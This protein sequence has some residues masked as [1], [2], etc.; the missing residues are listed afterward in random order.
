MVVVDCVE[1]CGVQTEIVLRQA[2]Q[3][4]VMPNL[5]VNDVECCSLE[6]QMEPED[7]YGPFR[8]ANEN[9]HVIT[10]TY[11]DALLGDVQVAPETGIVAFRQ[12]SAE[13][14]VKINV[15][16]MGVDKEKMTK[17]LWE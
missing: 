17:R 13:R 14:F 9:V 12:R 5:F 3:K 4:R 16:Q 2:L 1:S 8:S 15:S 7:M 10:A 6:L 11:N